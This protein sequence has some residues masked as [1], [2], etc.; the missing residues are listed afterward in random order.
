MLQVDGT[1]SGSLRLPHEIEIL[2]KV[3]QLFL[4]TGQH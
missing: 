2:D 4:S 1:M 3:G